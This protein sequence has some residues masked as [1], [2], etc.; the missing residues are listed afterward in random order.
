MEDHFKRTF[1]TSFR[2]FSDDQQNDTKVH[3]IHE[4]TVLF[5]SYLLSSAAHEE[6][7]VYH[8]VDES[9]NEIIDVGIVVFVEHCGVERD[10]DARKAD[11]ARIHGRIL[12]VLTVH[13]ARL[14]Q[15]VGYSARSAFGFAA[16]VA[17]SFSKSRW[18]AG[19]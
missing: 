18:S 1:G 15:V 5:V 9:L 6:E 16:R 2:D 12:A 17:S 4:S 10:T 8:L 11:H 14:G 3:T 7:G 19:R 13:V